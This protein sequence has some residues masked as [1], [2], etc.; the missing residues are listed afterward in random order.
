LLAW[1]PDRDGATHGHEVRAGE[2]PM[3]EHDRQQWEGRAQALREE[4]A[5]IPRHRFN[6]VKVSDREAELAHIEARLGRE[7]Q[8][9]A[10]FINRRHE[11][12]MRFVN[13]TE[14]AR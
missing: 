12:L 7:S 5:R 4:L 3:S 11:L 14:T 1:P 10:A 13:R 2:K 6:A 9:R 8:A